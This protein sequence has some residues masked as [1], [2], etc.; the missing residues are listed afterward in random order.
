MFLTL[1]FIVGK[2]TT[3]L[4]LTLIS[5][6]IST[7]E[8]KFATCHLGQIEKTKYGVPTDIDSNQ[9]HVFIAHL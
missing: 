1:S 3:I 8:H 5:R 2:F 6:S 7:A 9:N 4:I